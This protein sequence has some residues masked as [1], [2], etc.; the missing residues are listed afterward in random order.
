MIWDK[1]IVNG[2]E[3]TEEEYNKMYPEP[4]VVRYKCI[5][6]LKCD[7]E[8][9]V[10]C[11]KGKYYDVE[12]DIDPFGNHTGEFWINDTENGSS[13]QLIQEELDEYFELV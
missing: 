9:G 11:R 4:Q 6:T 13:I 7:P 2:K 3:V 12:F 8:Y 1:L 10:D 5:K